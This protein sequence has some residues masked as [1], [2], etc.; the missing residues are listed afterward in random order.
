MKMGAFTRLRHSRGFGIHSP[1]AYRFLTEVLRETEAYY[2]QEGMGRRERLLARLRAFVDPMQRAALEDVRAARVVIVPHDSTDI[3]EMDDNTILFIDRR[4]AAADALD[5]HLDRLC[6]GITFR[7][8]RGE[9]VIIPLSRLP[10]QIIE[11]R[12]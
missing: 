7:S 5:A 3:P 8:Q 9:S 10:R 4:G 1:F 6:H 11:T 12:F 2:D